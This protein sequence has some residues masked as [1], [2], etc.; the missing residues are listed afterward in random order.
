VASLIVLIFALATLG[1]ILP[2]IAGL[3]ISFLLLAISGLPLKVV[4]NRLRWPLIFLLPICLI[5]P[6]T[7]DAGAKVNLMSQD[8]SLQGA[9]MGLLMLIKG[10]SVVISA[11]AMLE[12]APFSVHAL[13]LRTL[14]VPDTLVQIILFS[15]RYIFVISREMENTFRSLVSRGFES[16]TSCQTAR[17]IGAV[18]GV[19]MIKSL[20]RSERIFMAMSSRG[21]SGRM[22]GAGRDNM[23]GIDWIKTAL[24]MSAALSLH[25]WE[26]MT[27][28][29]RLE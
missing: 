2:A 23:R 3:T 29:T 8:L 5:L 12:A 25:L 13:A 26:A 7:T 6:F 11:L 27:W 15:H 17:V 21:Y 28:I 24:V 9:H 1:T 19:L 14:K 10:V 20:D 18:L 22:V 16:K 4:A